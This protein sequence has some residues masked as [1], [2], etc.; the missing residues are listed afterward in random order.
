MPKRHNALLQ[1]YLAAASVQRVVMK[2]VAFGEPDD[3]WGTLRPRWVNA[4]ALECEQR[5]FL[6]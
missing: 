1:L 6:H 3:E 2:R 5:G 4:G